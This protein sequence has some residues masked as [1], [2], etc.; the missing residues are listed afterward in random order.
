MRFAREILNIE[1]ELVALGLPRHNI[2]TVLCKRAK[3]DRTTWQRWRL[4]ETAPTH[5]NWLK[6][7][8]HLHK[9]KE[10]L[11]NGKQVLAR[12]RRRKAKRTR[13]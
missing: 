13:R 9:L 10:D 12:R 8:R 4:G 6:I 2:A 1:D 5:L 3:F 11:S 7:E